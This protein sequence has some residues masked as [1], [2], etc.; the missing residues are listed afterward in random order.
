MTN[1]LIGEVV[2]GSLCARVL[3]WSEENTCPN[4]GPRDGGCGGAQAGSGREKKGVVCWWS[5][6]RAEKERGE[7]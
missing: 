6:L 7:A 1:K 3:G 5:S 2:E 4:P